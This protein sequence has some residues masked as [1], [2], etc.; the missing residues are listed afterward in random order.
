MIGGNPGNF[1]A[2]IAAKAGFVWVG[3]ISSYITSSV[4]KKG[5]TELLDRWIGHRE[6]A[7]RIDNDD[8]IN[9]HKIPAPKK[10]PFL[11]LPTKA[12]QHSN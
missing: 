9:G 10:S 11:P 8:S 12:R 2:C 7:L 5:K 6:R 4:W 1:T 3:A